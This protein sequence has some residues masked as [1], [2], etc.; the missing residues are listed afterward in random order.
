M[1][2]F[3]VLSLMHSRWYTRLLRQQTTSS[4]FLEIVPTRTSGGVSSYRL[5]VCAICF[6]SSRKAVAST[7]PRYSRG[8]HFDL[9]VVIDFPKHGHMMFMLC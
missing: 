5:A 9:L 7:L 6:P 2:I 3:L 1:L 8:T 4:R